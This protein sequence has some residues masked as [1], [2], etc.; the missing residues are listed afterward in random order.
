[1]SIRNELGLITRD[2]A[3]PGL[4]DYYSWGLRDGRDLILTIDGNYYHL[5]GARAVLP[6]QSVPSCDAI[7]RGERPL[8]SKDGMRITAFFH[9]Y[10]LVRSLTDCRD[11]FHTGIRGA[12]A[13]FSWDGR[14]IAFHAPKTDV[15]GFEVQIIDL[16]RRTLRRLSRLPGS[17]Y[18]PSWTRDGRLLFRYEDRE[19]R[20]FLLGTNVLSARE[21]PLP[22][23]RRLG[24]T[25][26]PTWSQLFEQSSAARWRAVL[27]WAP[28]SAHSAEA[29]MEFARAS[30]VSARPD[31]VQFVT[32]V[33]YGSLGTEAEQLRTELAGMLP[34]VVARANV[35]M[36]G[37]TNQIPTVLLFDGQQLVD[38]R[39]GTQRAERL[40]EWV[41][42]W[43]Q[44]RHRS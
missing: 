42:S 9:G 8:L 15:S 12:K 11:I 35:R 23:L 38:E 30:R 24:D 4:G 39:L 5:D 22:K 43:A 14:Y 32:A 40:L 25:P 29:L 1:M 26:P 33:D 34:T 21:E 31:K 41:R 28:W 37:A 7:G 27:V 10:L 44:R 2:V 18:F 19:F 17:S 13:D 36:T 6:A 16:Q 20:G 3:P